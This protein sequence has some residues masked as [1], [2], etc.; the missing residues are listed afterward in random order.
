MPSGALSYPQ[1]SS[2]SSSALYRSKDEDAA[3]LRSLLHDDGLV[4]II[5]KFIR[6]P[7]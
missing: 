3:L 4:A 2:L 6:R 7:P 5:I 1:E